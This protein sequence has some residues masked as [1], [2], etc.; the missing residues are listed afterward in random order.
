MTINRKEKTTYAAQNNTPQDFLFEAKL[1]IL[2][3]L[4]IPQY[5]D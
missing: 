5:L 3:Q 2:L 4:E 1:K